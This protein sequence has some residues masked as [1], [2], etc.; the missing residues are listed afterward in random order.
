M[1]GWEW[2][3]KPGSRLVWMGLASYGADGM[4]EERQVMEMPGLAWSGEGRQGE[5]FSYE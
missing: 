2:H 3:G 4:G 1:S 5:V